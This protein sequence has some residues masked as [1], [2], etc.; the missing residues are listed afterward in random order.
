M[1][2]VDP[3][4][5]ADDAARPAQERVEEPAPDREMDLEARQPD[6]LVVIEPT[7]GDRLGRTAIADRDAAPATASAQ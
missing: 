3:V 6:E 4:D 1:W 7:P 5:G 2:Q